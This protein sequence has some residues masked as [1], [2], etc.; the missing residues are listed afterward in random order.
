MELRGQYSPN[1]TQ[2][3]LTGLR[4]WYPV[5]Y[6]AAPEKI[7]SKKKYSTAFCAIF[8]DFS[9]FPRFTRFLKRTNIS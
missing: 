6:R 5:A 1:L 2:P 3:N 4:L 9:I 8:Y 7:F